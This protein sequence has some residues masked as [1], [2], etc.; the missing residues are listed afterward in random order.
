MVVGLQ[1]LWKIKISIGE[2]TWILAFGL[3]GMS[4]FFLILTTFLMCVCGFLNFENKHKPSEYNFFLWMLQIIL[5]LFFTTTDLIIFFI[6]FEVSLLPIFLIIIAWGSSV[7]RVLAGYYFFVYT[8]LGAALMILGICLIIME[9]GTTNLLLLESHQFNSSKQ[10]VLFFLFFWGFA[11]KIPMFPF[12][13]W[14]VEA[15]VESPTVGSVLLAGLLLKLGGYGFIKILVKMFPVACVY[16]LPGIS[17]LCIGGII[18]GSCNAIVQSD[19][20]RMIAYIS[21]AHMNFIVLGIFSG[22]IF[23]LVGSVVLMFG[24]GLVASGLFAV[25][26]ILYERY[27][28]RQIEYFGGLIL[29]MPIFGTLFFL[30]ILGNFGFPLTFNFVGELLILVGLAHSN[31]WMLFASSFGL[32]MSVAYSIMMYSKIMF[33]NIP[34]FIRIIKD[35]SLYEFYALFSLALFCIIF[36]MWPMPILDAIYLGLAYTLKY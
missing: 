33:G 3:N 23:G 8:S 5:I 6:C 14:L 9:C 32:V 24:H 13:L 2:L 36:G 15:H 28:S 17:A 27:Q 34:K 26:G 22:N 20:K 21:I 30:I 31:L 16:Y 11:I 1:F 10:L 29:A 25:V 19:V 7:R 12:H 4:M 35:V 18:L